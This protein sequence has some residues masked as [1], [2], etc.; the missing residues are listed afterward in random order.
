MS[1]EPIPDY[2]PNVTVILPVAAIA[3]PSSNP[4]LDKL[5]KET[6]SI[7]NLTVGCGSY[8]EYFGQLKAA[9]THLGVEANLKQ[10]NI[11][12]DEV[13]PDIVRE[14]LAVAQGR[15]KPELPQT[16]PRPLD[17]ELLESIADPAGR[18]HLRG[19]PK[20]DTTA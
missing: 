15:Q 9:L 13:Y 14:L 18:Q 3:T 10:F 20:A 8:R 17:A 19:Y 16:G 6:S 7:H 12:I 5:W 2:L 1:W 4:A 11:T